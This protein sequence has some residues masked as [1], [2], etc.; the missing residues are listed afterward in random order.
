MTAPVIDLF[1]LFRCRLPNQRCFHKP[2][3][4][5]LAEARSLVT[6]LSFLSGLGGQTCRGI[7]LANLFLIRQALFPADSIQFCQVPQSSPAGCGNGVHQLASDELAVM[8]ALAEFRTL[9][10]PVAES[11]GAIPDCE[12]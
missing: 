10:L 3:G 8:H 1:W 5:L 7:I 2:A 6:G 11:I 4:Y 9:A 12:G